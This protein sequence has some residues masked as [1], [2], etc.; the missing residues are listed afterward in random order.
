MNC[1]E[2]SQHPH[3]QL[4]DVRLGDDFEAAHLTGAA[5]NCVFEVAFAER[6]AST[7][8]DQNQTTVVYG[9]DERSLE[10]KIASEK[11]ARLGYT[12]IQI[13]T[14][15]F[16]EASAA[17]LPLTTGPALSP[18]PPLPEGQHK[19]DLEASQVQWT[20]RNLL[21]KHWGTIAITE[22]QLEFH[23]GALTGGALTLDLNQLSC[24]DLAETPMH[25]ILIAHLHNDDFFD[26]ENHPEAVLKITSA[27]ALPDSSPGRPNFSLTADL[28]LRGQTHPITFDAA[29]G[30]TPEGTAAAQATLSIDRTRWGIFYGSAKYFHRLA[31]HLV[32]DFIDFE[33]KIVTSQTG[34][35][36]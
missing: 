35:S 29:T 30:I 20:G 14:G 26:V 12:K 15:G 34:N 16:A 25:D 9:A 18:D 19:I 10:A 31:G 3:A 13:L 33:I 6:L 1:S 5:N 8:P 22:G 32:N 21:N 7:A 11:L 23:Q 2:L 27:T 36:S 4:L 17:G 28:T 24:T